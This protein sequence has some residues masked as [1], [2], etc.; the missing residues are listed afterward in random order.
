MSY[1]STKTAPD[2]GPYNYKATCISV[3]RVKY[4]KQAR[5]KLEKIESK[6]LT[7]KAAQEDVTEMESQYLAVK[8]QVSELRFSTHLGWSKLNK[9]I[10]SSFNEINM[11]YQARKI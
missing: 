11:K 8:S 10:E 7:L 9:E 4:E 6:I 1:L 2:L 5:A 3:D